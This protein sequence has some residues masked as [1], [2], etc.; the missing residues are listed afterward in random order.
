MC[1]TG[2][3]TLSQVRKMTDL[4][5]VAHPDDEILGACG[6]IARL[7]ARG[8]RI[9]VLTMSC[10]SATREDD[11][12]EKQLKTH[13]ILGI[14]ASYQGDCETMKF[15]TYDRFEMTRVIEDVLKQEDPDNV[16]THDLHDIH[17]D[18]RVLAEIVLEASKLP[19]RGHNL[20]KAI[21]G[22]YTMEIPSSSDWGMGFMPNTFF[23]ITEDDIRMKNELLREYYG[24]VIRDFPHPR[25]FSSFWA[26]A[27]YRGGQCG[28]K[29]AEAFHKVMEVNV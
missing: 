4:F 18:H 8:D 5:I 1:C 7:K 16:F 28:C 19:M 26:L 14:D 23:G 29:F 25:N 6:T 22:L 2:L 17:N 21:Q 12:A 20:C 24:G 13:E 9:A 3:K 27:R 15:A 10:K 11:L